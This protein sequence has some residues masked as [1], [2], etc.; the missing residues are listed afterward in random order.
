MFRTKFAEKLLKVAREFKFFFNI[1]QSWTCL[2]K[3]KR[4]Q[5]STRINRIL[6]GFS[7]IGEAKKAKTL[8]FGALKIDT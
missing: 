8:S 2:S 4:V 3:T 7:D 6:F 1:I 5:L